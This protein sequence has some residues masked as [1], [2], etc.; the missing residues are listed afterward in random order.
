MVDGLL[1]DGCPKEMALR[2]TALTMYDLVVL[3]DDSDSMELEE[4][5]DR[6][7]TLRQVLESVAKIY[8]YA[9]PE[10]IVSVRFFN[11]RQGTRNVTPE[12]VEGLLGEVEYSGLTM[13]GT[14]LKKKI[15]EPFVFNRRGGTRMQK[16]L[17]V[18]VIT[19]G[20][21]EGENMG[22][23]KKTITN[24]IA[25][26]KEDPLLGEHAVAFY[27]ARVGD[28]EGAKD[29]IESLDND[30]SIGN[31]IDCFPGKFMSLLSLLSFT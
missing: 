21:V 5:G 13:I 20:D 7:N 4:N 19:D 26:A 18:M 27:F 28:D 12:K 15:L 29:L 24:C 23:L 8:T 14:Q 10:G 11:T 16:P 22:F 30:K 6:P 25:R 31:W 3:L 1:K 9:R 2:F 17:L